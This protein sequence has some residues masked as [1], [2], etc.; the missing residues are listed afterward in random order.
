MRLAFARAMREKSGT[1]I[2]PGSIMADPQASEFI[3]LARSL[4]GPLSR[5]AIWGEGSGALKMPGNRFL[6]T[7]AGAQLDRLAPDDLVELDLKKMTDMQAGESVSEEEIAEAQTI[8]GQAAP[9]TDALLYAYLLGFEGVNMAVHIQPVE[10]NQILCSPRARQFAD[11]RSTPGE[12]LAF[13]SAM[14]L[15]S[16]ADP[17]LQLAREVRRR[18]ALWRDRYKTAPRV[19]LIQNHGMIA[20]GGSGAEIL[21]IIDTTL[22]AAQVFIGASLLGGPVFMTPS[23][24]THLE[25]LKAL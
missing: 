22:K 13:G 20:L 24:V 10:I 17:G 7:R 11:R 19:V 18:M 12:I 23:N 3:E 14:L 4:G 25:P 15:A 1:P 16:Y 8:R 21:K 6:A 9:T 5:M 2:F